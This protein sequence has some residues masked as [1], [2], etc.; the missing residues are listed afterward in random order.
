MKPTMH[1]NTDCAT[2]KKCLMTSMQVTRKLNQE[3]TLHTGNYGFGGCKNCVQSHLGKPGALCKG[4][5]EFRSV[6][7]NVLVKMMIGGGFKDI[8]VEAGLCASDSNEHVMSGKLY[9]R[10]MRVHQRMLDALERMLMT[11]FQ[12]H[13][14]LPAD[15]D[16]LPAEPSPAHLQ[17]AE[18]SED[19]K[20]FL[21]H[22]NNFQ[23]AIRHGDFRK[24]AKFWIQYCDC[25]WTSLT[26]Q[27]A[28]KENDLNLFIKS[29]MKM[30][31]L[32]LSADHLNYG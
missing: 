23:E 7:H 16:C 9:N 13:A 27:Q 4:C 15:S 24:T 20:D 10:S 21:A 22:F 29:I 6:S 26:F 19:C 8:V 12:Q 32:L 18:D 30:C 31:G 5:C 17:A 3:Y 1:P 14:Q 28:V 11:S 2:V 25:I